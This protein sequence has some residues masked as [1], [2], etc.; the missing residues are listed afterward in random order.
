MISDYDRYEFGFA[1]AAWI[2]LAGYAAIALI[3]FL[4][5]HSLLLSLVTGMLSVFTLGPAGRAKAEKR[6]ELLLAQFRD[7]LYSLSSSIAAGRQMEAALAEGLDDLSLIYGPDT[8]MIGE[9][10]YIVKVIE[11]SGKAERT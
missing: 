11:R 5:Y 6:R 4:F 9:L 7:L 2:V 10:R 3:V 1:E 8:P